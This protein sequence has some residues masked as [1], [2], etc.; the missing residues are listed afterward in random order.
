MQIPKI[1]RLMQIPKIKRLM[2]I[3]LLSQVIKLIAIECYVD[4]SEQIK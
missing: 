1:K 3:E 4:L 2:Q